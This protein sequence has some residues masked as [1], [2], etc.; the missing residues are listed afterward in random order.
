MLGYTVSYK[1]ITHLSMN[2]RVI[3]LA[4]GK[5]K[6]MNSGSPKVLMNVGGKPILRCLLDAIAESGVDEKPVVVVAPAGKYSQSDDVRRIAGDGCEFVVQEEQL[7]T[8]HAVQCVETALRG[9]ADAVMVLYGDHPFLCSETIRKIAE[10]HRVSQPAITMAVTT[11]DNFEGWRKILYDFGR[12][13]RN[14]K[15]EIE[16]SVEK[17]DATP[18]QLAIRELNPSF[19]C[20]RAEWLWE[21][22][23]ELDNLNAQKEYYLTDLVRI[24]IRKGDKVCTVRVDPSETV[25]V[26]TPEQLELARQMCVF[27]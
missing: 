8:G 9:T 1:K 23:K 25:G 21:N 6:R 26:N 20:Y 14:E 4:A 7:G 3:V 17:K 15:G 12:I 16:A 22:L 18:S 27:R 11:I 2:I 5:G 24:A 13:V 19:Y 10:A